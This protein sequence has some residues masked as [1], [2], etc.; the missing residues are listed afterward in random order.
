MSVEFTVLD[1]T[2]FVD[3]TDPRNPVEKVLVTFQTPDGRVDSLAMEKAGLTPDKR[4]RLIADQI[5]KRPPRAY[6]KVVVK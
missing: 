2:T 3:K 4:N 6:E 5:K 1:E